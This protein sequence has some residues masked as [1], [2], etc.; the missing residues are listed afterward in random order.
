MKNVLHKNNW[1]MGVVQLHVDPPPTPLIKSKHNDKLDK[2]FVTIKLHRDPKPENS[3][4]NES[5]MVLFDNG[6][7]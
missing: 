1:N 3:E 4:L 2:G 6:K 5:E 7:P